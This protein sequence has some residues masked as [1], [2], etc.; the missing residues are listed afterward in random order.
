MT[1]IWRS[2]GRSSIISDMK[3]WKSTR[4]LVCVVLPRMNPVGDFQGG[5]EVN[6]AVPLVSALEALDD[7]TAAGLNI[8]GRPLQG[9]DRRLFVDA[10]HQR[11]LR[12]VEVQADNIGRFRG[13]LR[14]GTDT[15]RAMPAQLNAL[16]AQHPSN[17]GVRDAE[18]RRQCTAIPPGQPWRRRALCLAI[19]LGR[20]LLLEGP[21][22]VGKTEVGPALAKALKTR[23]IRLQCYEGLDEARCTASQNSLVMPA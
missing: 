19:G 10:E 16:F 11:V 13:K 22:G 8:A 5:K 9:L 4:F 12:G 23:L 18:R 17:R 20:P 2:E 3:A 14:V 1:W 6:R 7:L 15:P 21:A